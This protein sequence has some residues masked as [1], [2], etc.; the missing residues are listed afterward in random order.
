MT[1]TESNMPQSTIELRV[2][3][4]YANQVVSLGTIMELFGMAGGKLSMMF[5]GD[6]GFMKAFDEV[7]FVAPAYEGDYLRVTATQLSAGNTSRR[8]KY[9]AY[10]VART[11]GIGQSPSHGEVLDP[12]I[13][14]ARATG[15]IVVPKELQRYEHS[16]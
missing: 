7:E 15:T 14:V 3:S 12:P 8:R 13:L 4:H 2:D 9:E 11:Y 6:A 10:V 5:D 1:Q 16:N